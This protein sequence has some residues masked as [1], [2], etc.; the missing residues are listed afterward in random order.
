MTTCIKC[1]CTDMR[2]CVTDGIPCSWTQTSVKTLMHGGRSFAPDE[3]GICSACDD[4]NVARGM[5]VVEDVNDDALDALFEPPARRIIL[6]GD[7][8]WQL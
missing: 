8:D 4:G 6:P 5:E 3:L 7:E 1:G 2:A